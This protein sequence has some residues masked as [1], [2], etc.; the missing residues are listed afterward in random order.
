MDLC[1]EI[2]GLDGGLIDVLVDFLH[3][4]SGQ[5]LHFHRCGHL[6]VI[7][8]QQDGLVER[9]AILRLAGIGD[10]HVEV[11]HL[12]HLVDQ[13]VA[14]CDKA[15]AV[16][17]EGENP[18]GEFGRVVVTI[19]TVGIERP[20][21]AG[22]Q[23]VLANIFSAV[24]GDDRPLVGLS[25]TIREIGVLDEV[26]LV[27]VGVHGNS[28]SI[29]EALGEANAV[30]IG[31][32]QRLRLLRP[33]VITT[34]TRRIAFR[35]ACANEPIVV[36]AIH[37]DEAHRAVFG[38]RD[39][40]RTHIVL[41]RIGGDL[42]FRCHLPVGVERVLPNLKCAVGVESAVRGRDAH[43]E[44]R[45]VVGIDCHTSAVAPLS[46]IPVL[47]E[48]MSA[49]GELAALPC[50]PVP[51]A[52]P[53]RMGGFIIVDMGVGD[54]RILVAIE[55]D[56]PHPVAVVGSLVDHSH[57]IGIVIA[58][59][60]AHSERAVGDDAQLFTFDITEN[61]TVSLIDI[62]H[63]EIQ[64]VWILIIGV[65]CGVAQI[66][67]IFSVALVFTVR[68]GTG[69]LHNLLRSE[70]EAAVVVGIR[71][72]DT[73]DGRMPVDATPA[74]IDMVG[75][76]AEDERRRIGGVISGG[77]TFL[78]SKVGDIA[79]L[80]GDTIPDTRLVGVT[81]IENH[82]ALIGKDDE[83]GVVMVVG[84]EI[85][86]DKHIGLGAGQP[87]ELGGLHISMHV[88]IADVGGVDRAGSILIVGSTRVG[89][90]APC[91]FVAHL[92]AIISLDAYRKEKHR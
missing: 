80:A 33:S 44:L 54:D 49:V 46:G 13:P 60:L 63:I 24:D 55:R 76:I 85:T 72:R 68:T 70:V 82:H 58:V 16:V 83:S 50:R 27:V 3:H 30:D 91:P 29:G 36:I 84:L 86:A 37:P 15:L 39:D 67:L 21:V 19:G 89:K 7:T 43:I 75:V 17:G 11:L 9:V 12:H 31:I 34:D 64:P 65:A 53:I 5:R 56:L 1:R 40:E 32:G 14:V 79:R 6:A 90:P 10:I 62:H 47:M 78:L 8:L 73:R 18:C 2:D 87:V 74:E 45:R 77:Q 52:V 81:R 71:H 20:V 42:R 57:R 88:D 23:A 26:A 51:M 41:R 69:G 59:G 61:R 25:D 66:D 28:H 4:L 38:A 92:K 48:R 22:K 35:I